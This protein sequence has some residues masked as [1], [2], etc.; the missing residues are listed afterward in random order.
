MESISVIKELSI[1]RHPLA[2]RLGL[3]YCHLLENLFVPYIF[4]GYV[5][6]M[7]LPLYIPL[8]KLTLRITLDFPYYSCKQEVDPQLHRQASDTST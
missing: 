5:L 8:S 1:Y 4:Y 7:S 3:L 2:S 6:L